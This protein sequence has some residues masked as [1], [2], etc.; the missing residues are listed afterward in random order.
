MYITDATNSKTPDPIDPALLELRP[1]NVVVGF[2][3]PFPILSL[4][5]CGSNMSPCSRP[6]R[7]LC[8]Q[9]SGSVKF[10]GMPPMSLFLVPGLR[11]RT[12]LG[13]E[14][15]AVSDGNIT[16]KSLLH[17]VTCDFI[18]PPSPLPSN[19]CAL[20][21]SAG[22]A[23]FRP[24]SESILMWLPDLARGTIYKTSWGTK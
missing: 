16:L 8:L 14:N 3:I 10:L 2:H 9:H 6:S 24:Q 19:H 13:G 4:H 11:S 17:G 18:T 5:I 22:A 1:R 7:I 15:P 23:R 21:C 12:G 20:C